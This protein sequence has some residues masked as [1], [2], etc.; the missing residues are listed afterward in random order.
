ML[1]APNACLERRPFSVHAAR[2]HIPSAAPQQYPYHNLMAVT[3]DGPPLGLL[4]QE[5]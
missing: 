5:V 4:A 3:P 2:A 1:V